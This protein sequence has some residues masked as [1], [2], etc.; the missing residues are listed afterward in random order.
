MTEQAVSTN[1]APQ[2]GLFH[3][4]LPLFATASKH[5]PARQLF[6]WSPLLRNPLYVSLPLL[7]GPFPA[8]FGIAPRT[9]VA[10]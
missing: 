1:T 9:E 7:V 4:T 8:L 10:P 5:L 6:P 2:A 3:G